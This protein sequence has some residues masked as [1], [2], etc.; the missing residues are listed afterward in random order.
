MF[1][2]SWF[3]DKILFNNYEEYKVQLE[4]DK[5]TLEL[6]KKE[7]GVENDTSYIS[8]LHWDHMP[9]TYSIVNEDFCSDMELL[10]IRM[11]FDIIKNSTESIISFK[12]INNT[13]DIN[14]SCFDIQEEI[15][16]IEI[17][18]NI[19]FNYMNSRFRPYETHLDEEIQEMISSELIK[20]TDNETIFELCYFNY[21]ELPF[22]S[23]VLGDERYF[24]AGHALP[25]IKDNVITSAEI[26]FF[27]NDGVT[28]TCSY[29]SKEIH[30]IMH[31]FGIDHSIYEDIMSPES[32][33]FVVKRIDEIYTSCLK[34]IYSNGE[35]EG[36]CSDVLF[37]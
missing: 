25:I 37:L 33:C 5:T 29:P 2:A 20:R 28:G 15:S 10:R 7:L 14:I 19:T 30:E 24:T 1:F 27:I 11:A 35:L 17:C 26:V 6:M 13:G 8:E 3:T 18:E 21:N 23:W 4:K 9:I 16:K 12:E 32:N 22:D 36:N 34:Y 31:S